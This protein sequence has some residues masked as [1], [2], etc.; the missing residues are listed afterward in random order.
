MKKLI[1]A[2]AITAAFAGHAAYAEEAAAPVATPDNVVTYNVGL[3]S[4]YRYRG[5]SQSQKEP[6]LSLGADYT[7][8]PTGLYLGTWM[9]MIKWIKAT[10]LMNGSTDSAP[11]E[12][13][14]YGGKRGEIGGGLTYDVGGLYYYYP[15]NSLKTV[16]N[17]LKNANTFEVYGQLGYGPAYLKYSHATTDTFATGT[18][19]S[20]YIDAGINY[21]ITETLVLNAHVGHQ[22]YKGVTGLDYEDWKLG[23]TKDFGFVVGSIA[24]IDTNA[25]SSKYIWNGTTV[26]KATVVATLV[27]NF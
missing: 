27:K 17:V 1:L 21:P 4:E 5:I 2:S 12:W 18:K 20:Y 22:T 24:Y 23:V 3:A 26:S 15:G 10:A 7:N 8:N 13:D 9:S 16:P 6:A 19:D 11:V 14:I 25:D